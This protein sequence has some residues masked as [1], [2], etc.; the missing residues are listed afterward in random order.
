MTEK[1]VIEKRTFNVEVRAEGE[2]RKKIR[3][4]A[5]VFDKET[6]IWDFMEVVRRSAFDEAVETDDVVAL[7]NHNDDLVLGRTKSGTLKLSVDDVGLA[8]EIDPPDTQWGRDAVTTIERGDVYQMSFAFDVI[9]EKWTQREGQLPL[10]ELLKVKLYD[11]SPVTYPAYK[12]TEVSVRAADHLKQTDAHVP[13]AGSADVARNRLA[14][15][16]RAL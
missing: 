16:E 13:L 6:Q 7:W 4:H 9:D 3:G 11:V 10:R 14:I 12:E 1:R 5:A 2:G 8:I 15:A